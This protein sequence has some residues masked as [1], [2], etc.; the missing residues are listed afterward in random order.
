MGGERAPRLASR[1]PMTDSSADVSRE[2]VGPLV[3]T[4]V[5]AVSRETSANDTPIMREVAQALRVR[6]LRNERWPAP[7]RVR[8]FTVANQKGGVGKTTSAVNIAAA[9]A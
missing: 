6:T 2:T 7:D 3:E 1:P 8:V 5:E 4:L 9:L